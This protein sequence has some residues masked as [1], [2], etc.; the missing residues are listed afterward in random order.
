MNISNISIPV[1]GCPGGMLMAAVVCLAVNPAKGATPIPSWFGEPGTYRVGYQF[2]TGST[3]P[4][5]EIISEPALMPTVSI[6]LGG[7]S[8][9]W[10]DSS[11][12]LALSGVDEDGAWDLGTAGI[13][14]ILSKIATSPPDPGAFYQVEFQVF[15]VAYRGITSLPLFSTPGNTPEGLGFSQ[16]TVAPDPKFFGAT[17]EGMVWTGLIDNITGNE[18]PF[19]ITAPTNN[20][21]VVDTV[22]IFTKVT[23]VPEPSGV[24]W[25]VLAAAGWASRR[26][27][28]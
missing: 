2:P 8:S 10:Q 23:L 27:R 1:R 11:D 14:S 5:P 25:F 18:V 28:R 16:F 9:G 17:W 22:E 26:H 12:P 21:S 15:V 19:A 3:S 24:V 13:L 20:L 4:S 6:A 7:F